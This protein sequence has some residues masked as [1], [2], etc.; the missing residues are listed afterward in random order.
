PRGNSPPHCA[1]R[2]PPP[3]PPAGFPRGRPSPAEIDGTKL[4]SGL[5]WLPFTIPFAITGQPAISVPCGFTAGGL[6]VGLQIIGRRH[7]DAMVL[8]AAAAFEAARPWA[9]RRPQL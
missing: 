9:E 7:A 1:L 4:D 2:P 8:R 6:P 5:Q 3:S